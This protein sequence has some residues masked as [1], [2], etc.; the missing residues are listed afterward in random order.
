MSRWRSA[1][2]R[3]PN[4]LCQGKLNFGETCLVATHCTRK[5][6]G[7]GLRNRWHFGIIIPF[8]IHMHGDSSRMHRSSCIISSSSSSSSNKRERKGKKKRTWKG[9]CIPSFLCLF[10]SFPLSPYFILCVCVCL[11]LSY[12][13]HCTDIFNFRAW[14]KEKVF[15]V[16]SPV[17]WK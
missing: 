10:F 3:S 5:H 15:P 14:K 7:G 4:Y 9:N 1:V 17:C 16:S 13:A 6:G 11:F 8:S 2:Q 12:I